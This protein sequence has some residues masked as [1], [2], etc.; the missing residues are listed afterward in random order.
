MKTTWLKAEIAARTAIGLR[1]TTLRHIQAEL[2]R[3]GYRL[4]RS[5]DCAGVATWQLG[6]HAGR[7]YPCVTARI[8]E[9]DT[10]LSF[11]HENAKRDAHFET[12]QSL[13]FSGELFAVNRGAIFEI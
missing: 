3:L 1:P 7:S 5:G 6:P 2:D 12:L 11:A 4:D 9:K 13:R 8:V 10:G